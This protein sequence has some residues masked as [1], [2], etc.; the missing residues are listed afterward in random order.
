MT[1]TT[2]AADTD[3]AIVAD[4][5]VSHV[6]VYE[7]RAEV[8]R[9][10]TV[11]IPAGASAVVF[12]GLSP[13]IDEG[14]VIARFEGGAA[15]SDGDAGHVDDV[16][17]AR[18]HAVDGGDAIEARR[19]QRAE[20]QA[21]LDAE[22]TPL[23]AALAV[24]EQQRRAIEA[25][26]KL[27]STARAR[28]FGR[29]EVDVVAAS[30]ELNRLQQALADADEAVIQGRMAVQRSELR[31]AAL[32]STP[33]DAGQ[34]TRRVCDVTLRVSSTQAAD[35][36]LVVSTVVPCAAWRPSHEASLHRDSDDATTGLVRF[37]GHAA[38]WN[39]T[40][41]D[42][43][44]ASL[45]LSTARPSQGAELPTLIEDRLRL[46]TKT[47]EEKKTIVVEHRTEAVPKNATRGGAPG[48]DDGGEVRAFTVP[49]AVI[50]DDGR[51]HRVE[52]FRFEAP[53]AVVRLAVPEKAEQV[54]VRASFKNAGTAPLLAGPVSL[55]DRGAFLGTGD[56]L[57]TGVGED[58]DLAFG[59]DD[60]LRVVLARKHVEEKK[61]IGKN[62]QHWVQEATLTSTRSSSASVQVLLR[63]PVSELAQV[64][65]VHSAAHSTVPEP[66]TD[67]HGLVKLPVTIEGG[68]DK[69]VALAFFF[70][71]SGDVRLP[72]PW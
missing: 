7:D 64:K 60:G 6:T 25:L 30:A 69:T 9:K 31:M 44:G 47:A 46:R 58:L 52:L 28:R 68:H 62:V 14:R 18:R 41:E 15:N 8:T 49:H 29:G 22:H 38:V 27:S 40:G 24:A 1:M 61:L 72:D 20:A 39:R 45:T 65:V 35:V 17:V 2:T 59:S 10:A 32:S 57:Y 11:R 5:I 4:A 42:W 70:D 16:V 56:I 37:V 55:S 50:P 67:A 66:K 33:L 21:R 48:V 34:R 43:R 13:L 19:L 26:A 71:L 12:R 51:P 3:G 53:C 54:F 23:V 36:T 63:L